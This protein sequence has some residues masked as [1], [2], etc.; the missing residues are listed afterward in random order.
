[1]L[2]GEGPTGRVTKL[3][4]QEEKKVTRVAPG[5][6]VHL[7]VVGDDEGQDAQDARLTAALLELHTLQALDAT[8]AGASLREVAEGLFGTNRRL[9]RQRTISPGAAPDISPVRA[10]ALGFEL[11]SNTLGRRWRLEAIDFIATPGPF[12]RRGIWT[13]P[14]TPPTPCIPPVGGSS[15]GGGGSRRCSGPQTGMR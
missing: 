14:P 7:W 6:P 11:S 2:I 15:S 3:L 8:L 1:M 13:T 10:P 4:K 9:L 5:V 12:L